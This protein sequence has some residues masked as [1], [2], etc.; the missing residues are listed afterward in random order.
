MQPRSNSEPTDIKIHAPISNEHERILTFE[1]LAYLEKLHQ[2]FEHTRRDLMIARSKTQTRINHDSMLESVRETESIHTRDRQVKEPPADLQDRR[3]EITG[4]VSRK[5]G[6]GAMDSEARIFM[7]DFEDADSP[8]LGNNLDWQS[9]LADTVRKNLLFTSPDGKRDPQGDNPTTLLV[10][11]RGWHLH[12]KHLTV[13]G[14]PISAALFDFG[15][16]FFHNA[17]KL[18]SNG[19]GPYFYLPKLESHREARLWNQVFEF[20]EDYLNIPRRSI[21]TTVLIET[22]PAA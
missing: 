8:T 1:A 15:L 18:L 19:S 9:N 14:A 21:R 2:V 11:P 20:S 5:M 10:R 7:A 12:E 3:V 17:Q 22:I 4:P 13:G 6:I 16:Y